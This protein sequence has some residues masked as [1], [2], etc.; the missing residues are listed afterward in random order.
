MTK[1]TIALLVVCVLFPVLLLWNLTESR[2]TKI[3][4]ARQNGQTCVGVRRRLWKTIAKRYGVSPSRA[5]RW[6]KA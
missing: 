6:M 2:H 5:R 4:R 1:T 3:Q